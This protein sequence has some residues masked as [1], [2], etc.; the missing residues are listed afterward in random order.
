MSLCIICNN[1]QRLSKRRYCK[2]CYSERK[3]KLERERYKRV[4]NTKYSIICYF[5]KKP[6]HNANRKTTRFCSECWKERQEFI[7]KYKS[8]NHYNRQEHKMI[9]EKILNKKLDYNNVVHHLDLNPRNN[10]LNNLIVLSRS[11]HLALHNYLYNE[12]F[13]LYKK[14]N[15]NYVKY[16]NIINITNDFFNIKKYIPIYLSDI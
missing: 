3:R 2:E 6:F 7:K 16:F 11:M 1:N 10:D 9:A 12:E 14:Y 5:C 4:G 15:K 13:K 8:T